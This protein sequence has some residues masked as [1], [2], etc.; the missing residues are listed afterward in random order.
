M[1]P[2]IDLNSHLFSYSAMYDNIEKGMELKTGGDNGTGLYTSLN[3]D[4]EK[5][6]II[7]SQDHN[8]LNAGSFF[9]RR[10]TTAKWIMD[11]WADPAFVNSGWEKQEQEALMRMVLNHES[12]RTHVGFVAQRA[13]NAYAEGGNNM[14]WFPGDLVV[15]FAGCWV[16]DKCAEFFEKFWSKIRPE[17]GGG[18][19]EGGWGE[20]S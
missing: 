1:T 3:V 18:G 20:K 9:I 13:I 11:L 4:V 15:H 16:Q 5:I 14:R 10:S 17:N 7:I 12:V 8:G 6:D 19:M 2:E